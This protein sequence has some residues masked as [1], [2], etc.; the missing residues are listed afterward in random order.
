MV[1]FNLLALNIKMKASA[2][3]EKSQELGIL[4]RL[5][6][7]DHIDKDG[8][9]IKKYIKKAC[10]ILVDREGGDNWSYNDWKIPIII[11]LKAGRFG[12]KVFYVEDSSYLYFFFGKNERDAIKRMKERIK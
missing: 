11:G 7:H 5:Y 1:V 9:Y 8:Y 10:D 12:K 4:L 2:L 3:V 6:L